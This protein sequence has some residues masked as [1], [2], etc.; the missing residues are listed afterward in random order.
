M[1]S[2]KDRVRINK[3]MISYG[4]GIK[5]AKRWLIVAL[6]LF[7][8]LTPMTNWLIIFSSKIKDINIRW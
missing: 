2:Y 6:W 3:D 1:I 5:I 7:C 8:V 4:R